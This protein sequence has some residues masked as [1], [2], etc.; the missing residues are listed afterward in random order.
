MKICNNVFVHNQIYPE[1]EESTSEL[2][3]N[4][5]IEVIGFIDRY[6]IDNT[7][8]A[9]SMITDTDPNISVLSIHTVQFKLFPD[10]YKKSDEISKLYLFT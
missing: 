10:L 8:S 6:S 7:E 9:D 3:L 5:I 2:K 1:D 4:N